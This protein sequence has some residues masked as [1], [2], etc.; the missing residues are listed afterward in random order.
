METVQRKNRS[1]KKTIV[2]FVKDNPGKT[3]KE[4]K[5]AVWAIMGK[6][7]R[8]YTRESIDKLVA[9]GLLKKNEDNTI[10]IP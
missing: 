8:W 1:V 10:V 3:A 2:Q 7:D 6:Q 9:D 5:E 4:I